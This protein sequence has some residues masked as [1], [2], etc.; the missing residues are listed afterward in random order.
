[1]FFLTKSKVLFY[2]FT[3]FAFCCLFQKWRT[4]MRCGDE[5]VMEMLGVLCMRLL[6]VSVVMGM[7]TPPVLIWACGSIN[8]WI[9]VYSRGE[10][11]KALHHL[12][13]CADSYKAPVD[14][15]A[16][17]PVIQ[18]ALG[19]RRQAAAVAKQVF[20]F[21]NHLWGARHEPA[22]AG[23]FKAV[24]GRDDWSSLTDYQ[25]WMVVTAAGGANMRVGPS[26]D[27]PAI[28]AVK[29]GMQVKA[30]A[31]QG[32]WI[33]ARPVGPGAVDS[34]FDGKTGY[35]HESLLMAY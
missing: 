9:A 17:L 19:S 28:T 11:H 20:G 33:E 4:A 27:S 2:K 22:Y 25:D 7:L 15:T 16:L 1:M 10:K 32:E 31:R 35:I 26:L 12:L 14:D 23:V 5:Q 6:V 24:T 29:F 34:R 21:F 18:E 30:L 13:D 3:L 8:D